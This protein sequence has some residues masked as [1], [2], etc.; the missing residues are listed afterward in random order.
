MVTWL[1]PRLSDTTNSPSAVCESM[2]K[3]VLGL[4]VAPTIFATVC[5]AAMSTIVF[6]HH[7]QKSEKEV[8]LN[9]ECSRRGWSR[10][11]MVQQ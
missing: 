11:V 9:V 2:A 10:D 4:G 5:V 8:R 3:R 7:N 1:L 6:V